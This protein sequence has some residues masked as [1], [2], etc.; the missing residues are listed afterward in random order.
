MKKKIC[1]RCEKLLPATK[2]YFYERE[3]GEY[4]LAEWCIKCWREYNESMKGV[5]IVNT[6]VFKGGE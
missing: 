1:S 6:G 3:I 2:K 5:K 4:G